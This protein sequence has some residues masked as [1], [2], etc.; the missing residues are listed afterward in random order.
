MLLPVIST[1]ASIHGKYLDGWLLNIDFWKHSQLQKK[2]QR[3]KQID[4]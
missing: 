2:H 3:K 4:F 1:T